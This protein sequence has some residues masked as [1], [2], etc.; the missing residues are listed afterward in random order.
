MLKFDER[1]EKALHAKHLARCAM[2]AKAAKG[3]VAD[4]TARIRRCEEI[5]RNATLMALR[6]ELTLD[7]I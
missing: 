6:G 5:R 4:L 3:D 7:N 2:A 1:L